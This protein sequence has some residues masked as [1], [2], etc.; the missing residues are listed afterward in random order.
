MLPGLEEEGWDLEPELLYLE[1]L[2]YEE[3]REDGEREREPLS[4]KIEARRSGLRAELRPPDVPCRVML[5]LGEYTL[6]EEE[7][8]SKDR[9]RSVDVIRG[10][11]E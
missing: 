8:R 7:G 6:G 3:D 11:D 4:P 10:E 9:R 5:E 1:G 2:E